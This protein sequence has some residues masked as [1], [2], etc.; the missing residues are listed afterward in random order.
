MLREPCSIP[1]AKTGAVEPD[2]AAKTGRD[3]KPVVL[4]EGL[5]SSGVLVSLDPT[6]PAAL[7]L[8]IFSEGRKHDDGG[9]D[10]KAVF[11]LGAADG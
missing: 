1:A 8:T 4:A 7:K 11:S 5:Y 2:S 10:D 6:R 3:G 9:G